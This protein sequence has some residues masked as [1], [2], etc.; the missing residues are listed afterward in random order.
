MRHLARVNCHNK[1]DL[2]QLESKKGNES[3]PFFLGRG[4]YSW[5]A[6]PTG[7]GLSR[8]VVAMRPLRALTIPLAEVVREIAL[9]KAKIVSIGSEVTEVG[10]PTGFP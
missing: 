6:S 1:Q 4:L 9:N 10:P 7:A 5:W 2:K 3:F 8:A